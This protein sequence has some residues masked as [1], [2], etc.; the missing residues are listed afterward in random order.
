MPDKFIYVFTKEAF[1]KLSLLG[2]R[3]LKIDDVNQIFVFE[4]SKDKGAINFDL[5]DFDFLL[6]NILT[7]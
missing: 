1:D 3:A 2:Y 5:C 4:N 7:F 6:S